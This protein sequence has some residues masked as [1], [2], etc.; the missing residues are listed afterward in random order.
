MYFFG[1]PAGERRGNFRWGRKGWEDREFWENWEN[2][3]NCEISLNPSPPKK[4]Q[5]SQNSR[6]K[7]I[8]FRNSETEP[9]R[10][11]SA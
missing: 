1:K 7:K 8:G 9:S 2:W 5:N 11:A 10:D 6:T 3:E 4:S